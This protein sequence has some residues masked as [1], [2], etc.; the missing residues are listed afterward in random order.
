MHYIETDKAPHDKLHFFVIGN[1]KPSPL[2][3]EAMIIIK[4]TPLTM[5]RDTGAVIS[6]VSDDICRSHLPQ[7]WLGTDWK[8]KSGEGYQLWFSTCIAQYPF[9][10]EACNWC[11]QYPQ[12]H[13]S[14]PSRCFTEISQALSCTFHNEGCHSSGA[15]AAS[16]IETVSHSDWVVPI[17]VMS[18]KDG[19]FYICGN[20]KMTV[21][22]ALGVDQ[23]SLP[24]PA[25]IFVTV[26]VVQKFSKLVKPTS[27]WWSAITDGLLIISCKQVLIKY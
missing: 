26:A 21:N 2:K 15:E 8:G 24:K 25:K 11:N 22:N 19:A 17:V 5:E 20:Y 23:S 13:T 1:A 12:G 3:C 16:I 4:C 9:Q 27:M 10:E 14:G 18:K 7:A 6:I